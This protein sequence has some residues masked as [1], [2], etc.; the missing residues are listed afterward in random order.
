[1][2]ARISIIKKIICISLVTVSLAACQQTDTD[3]E[4]TAAATLAE[5]KRAHQ[6]LIS[7]TRG[8]LKKWFKYYNLGEEA[9]TLFRLREVWDT[10]L[11][12][13]TASPD[14]QKLYKANK[15]L[16]KLS[17]AED[18]VLDIYTSRL[19]FESG[20]RKPKVE[21][22]SPDSEAAIVSPETNERIRLIFCNS[23][24]Q[25]HDGWWR[26]EEEIIVVGLIQGFDNKTLHPALWHINL[27]TQLVQQFTAEAPA[28][29]DKRKN[30]LQDKVWDEL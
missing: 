1:M 27:S 6:Q 9:D 26:N 3:T 23:A 10:D 15:K 2:G 12:K 13:T 5:E 30:Y 19:A 29:P 16:F 11:L 20:R 24:C 18:K 4:P 25:F 28:N 14:W 21:L 8:E 7:E 17:P 22:A